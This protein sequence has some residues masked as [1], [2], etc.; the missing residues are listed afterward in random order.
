[1]TTVNIDKVK[2]NRMVTSILRNLHD[3]GAH[4][5][6]V[7]MALGEALGRVIA[8]M[9]TIGGTDIIKR[10]LFQ[11]AVNQVASAVSASKGEA[12]GSILLPS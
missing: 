4:P 8:T 7:V 10:E 11:L 12:A 3:S 2:V 6:E 5:A 1:M 9:D